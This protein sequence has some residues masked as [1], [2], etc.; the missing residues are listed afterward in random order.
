MG[1]ALA[2]S[3]RPTGLGESAVGR[4]VLGRG[5]RGASGLRAWGWAWVPG[6]AGCKGQL[7]GARGAS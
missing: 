7:P 4:M 2:Q 1:A 5:E 6:A 3:V